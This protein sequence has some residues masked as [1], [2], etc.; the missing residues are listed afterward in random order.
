MAACDGV[1]LTEYHLHI[2]NVIMQANFAYFFLL[3][4]YLHDLHKTFDCFKHPIA[5]GDTHR[6]P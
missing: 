4:I 1:I 6:Q 3:A 2:P 5:Y